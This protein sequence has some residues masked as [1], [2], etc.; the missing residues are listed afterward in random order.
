MRKQLFENKDACFHV[1]Y[2]GKLELLICPTIEKF[3]LWY[4]KNCHFNNFLLPS[5]YALKFL[6]AASHM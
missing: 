4:I 3:K 2:I 6:Y 1:I 5:S